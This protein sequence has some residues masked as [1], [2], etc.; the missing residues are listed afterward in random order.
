MRHIYH[1][2][3]TLLRLPS[4]HQLS[5]IPLE[6]RAFFLEKAQTIDEQFVAWRLAGALNAE[7]KVISVSAEFDLVLEFV[8]P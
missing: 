3:P 1:H 4:S 6:P 5:Q 8:M 2:R 7:D